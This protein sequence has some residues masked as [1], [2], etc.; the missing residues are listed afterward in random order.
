M[1]T[2]KSI[3]FGSASVT[4]DPLPIRAEWVIDGHKISKT[5]KTTGTPGQRVIADLVK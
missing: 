5:V 3:E 2:E 4:L 1:T